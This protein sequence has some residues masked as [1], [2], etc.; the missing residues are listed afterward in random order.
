MKAIRLISGHFDG[1]TETGTTDPR[2][3]LHKRLPHGD[4]VNST[5]GQPMTHDVYRL[6][7]N[8]EAQ[9][10]YNCVE[11]AIEKSVWVKLQKI[12]HPD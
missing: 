1:E 2:Q 4:W 11:Q 12:K 6:G 5:S 7:K 9:T 10:V 8:S 3:Q